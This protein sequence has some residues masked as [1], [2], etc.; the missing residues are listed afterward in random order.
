VPVDAVAAA[1]VDGCFSDAYRDA[2]AVLGPD[3]ILARAP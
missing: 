2:F 3:D 1:V